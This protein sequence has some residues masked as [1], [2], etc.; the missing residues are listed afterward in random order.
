MHILHATRL[1]G[2]DNKGR[3]SGA[4][5]QG[6]FTQATKPH[7]PACSK[8]MSQVTDLHPLLHTS[9]DITLR[10]TLNAGFRQ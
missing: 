7:I 4:T 6:D 8:T 3:W 9:T 10:R 1:G 2:R 5:Q